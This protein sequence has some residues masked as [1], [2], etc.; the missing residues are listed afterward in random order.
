MLKLARLQKKGCVGCKKCEK[1]CTKDAIKVVDNLAVID[2]TKC[3][4]CEDFGICAREC[5]MGCIS[6]LDLCGLQSVKK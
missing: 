1:V 2:Y 6:I 4:D 3:S 5:T